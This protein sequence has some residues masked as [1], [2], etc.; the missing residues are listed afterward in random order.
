MAKIDIAK[1]RRDLGDISQVELGEMLGGIDQAMIS[2]WE[3]GETEPS[4]AS[5]ILLEQLI[6][7]TGTAGSE[8]FAA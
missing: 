3:R 7:R 5:V 1:L 6:K 4:K 8:E 2:R